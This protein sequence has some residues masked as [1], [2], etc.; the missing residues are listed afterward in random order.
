[1]L[2]IL[3][4]SGSVPRKLRTNPSAGQT[5]NRLTAHDAA[6]RANVR[7][8]GRSHLAGKELVDDVL[9]SSHHATRCAWLYCMADKL[10][11]SDERQLDVGVFR[12][13]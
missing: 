12:A 3:R 8:S 7:E 13:G 9:H 10:C 4:L 11:L 6:H 5:T 2:R 1:V